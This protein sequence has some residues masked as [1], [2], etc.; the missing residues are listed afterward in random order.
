MDDA[1]KKGGRML[2][3]EEEEEKVGR[4]RN[5]RQKVTKPENRRGSTG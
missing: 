5:T 2:E 4:P 1:G 3:E